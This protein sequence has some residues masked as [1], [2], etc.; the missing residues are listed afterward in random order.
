MPIIND[1][2][3]PEIRPKKQDKHLSCHIPVTEEPI[4]GEAKE[5]PRNSFVFLPSPLV[6]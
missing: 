1:S 5:I 4:V 3:R 6:Y 2:Q